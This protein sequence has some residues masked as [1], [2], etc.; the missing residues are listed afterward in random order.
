M[1]VTP[2][3]ETGR[4]EAPAP[5]AAVAEGESA[6]RALPGR[7]VAFEPDPRRTAGYRVA[8][9]IFEAILGVWF[10]PR[11]LGRQHIPVQGPVI[12]AP[13]HRS[14]ADFGFT[15]FVTPR[16]L[17]FMA[18]ADLWRSG[19]LGWLL[20]NLGAFPVHR[21][22]ADREAL[23]RAEEVLRR[24]QVLVLFPEGARREGP[25]VSD[26][27]EGAAFLAARTGAPIVPIGIANSDR[28]MPKGS[29][30]PKPWRID[31]VVGEAIPAPPPSAGGRMPRS[32]VHALS[33]QVAEAIQ[34]VYDEARIRS[35]H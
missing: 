20:V 14:F 4:G 1:A 10:R 7:G 28:S 22:S 12:L 21:E 5:A 19:F 2:E 18:K 26:L 31:V 15:A 11:V 35:G 34:E 16:K 17:F 25:L 27:Q 32:R 13:V 8:R 23:R 9:A 29:R 24:G 6:A 30:V 3:E 33:E